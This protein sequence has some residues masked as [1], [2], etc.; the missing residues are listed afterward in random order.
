MI[1]VH[2]T[3]ALIIVV[4]GVLIWIVELSRRAKRA[5]TSKQRKSD[6]ASN[7]RDATTTEAPPSPSAWTPPKPPE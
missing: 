2:G 1:T 4:L 5:A 3:V 6:G 7:A